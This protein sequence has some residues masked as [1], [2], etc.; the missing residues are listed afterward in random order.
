MRKKGGEIERRRE[1]ISRTERIDGRKG[2]LY[3]DRIG[4]GRREE[5]GI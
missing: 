2:G 5:R 4:N 3:G 1:T